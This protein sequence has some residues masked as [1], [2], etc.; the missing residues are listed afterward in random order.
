MVGDLVVIRC[1]QRIYADVRVLAAN[2]LKIEASAITGDPRPIDYTPEVAASH[3]S[4]FD[5]HNVAFKGSYCTGTNGIN[6]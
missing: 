6:D 5:A 1:G 4:V 2:G 3:V